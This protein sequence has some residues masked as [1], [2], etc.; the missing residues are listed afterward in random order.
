LRLAGVC[1]FAH[2][3]PAPADIPVAPV[4][5]FVANVHGALG[6]AASLAALI[7]R[8]RS[9][10]GQLVAVT[11]LEAAALM[12]ASI[13]VRPL[14]AP[15][16]YSTPRSGPGAPFFRL[17]RAGDGEWFF[18][19]ALVPTIFLQA[20]DALDLVEVMVL[21]GVDGEFL[22]LLSAD[23]SIRAGAVLEERF[24]TRPRQHWLDL[25]AAAA[26][27]AAPVQSRDV[28]AASETL[29]A[30]GGR[31][32]LE[33]PTLGRVAVPASPISLSAMGSRPADP[34]TWPAPVPAASVWPGPAPADDP[35]PDPSTRRG[36]PLAGVRVLDLSQFVAGP[37][38]P[39]LLAQWGADVIKVETPTGDPYRLY[40]VPF[41]AVNQG[42]RSVVLDLGT[43]A[44]A[45]TLAGL[46][47]GADVLVD[48]LRPSLRRRL[49]LETARL[50]AINPRLVHTTL[51]AFGDHGPLAE[52]P[53]FDPLLQALSGL[54][55]ACGPPGEPYS[56]T[57]PVHDVAGGALGALGTLAAL[58][59]RDGRGGGQRVSYSLA[60]ATLLVQVEE[61]TEYVGRPP[62]PRRGPDPLGAEPTRRCYR[63]ADGW[64]AV[65]AASSRDP[66]AVW[67]GGDGAADDAALT[68]LVAAAAATRT[69]EHVVAELTA[70]GIAAAP[71]LAEAD[72]AADAHLEGHG[73]YHV[74]HG[75]DIGRCLVVAPI[76]TW[77]R[78]TPA[79]AT[80]TPALGADTPTWRPSPTAARNASNDERN[81]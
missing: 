45:A 70:L 30:V 28:W 7:E 72:L 29:A 17:Y 78:S 43:E 68:D 60:S 1:G 38:G 75:P 33:H 9:G 39:T 79:A 37:L 48:N 80:H 31:T 67:A 42:K 55:D 10:L 76:G 18:L 44:G 53:G 25:F 71:V 13:L 50:H 14:D 15:M 56:T 69:T 3:Q 47:A 11:G 19:G 8:R 73:V 21:P 74:V 4:G 26:V 52:A 27:P 23:V 58:V 35:L 40:N 46:V 24:A 20:L 54:M 51:T 5:P 2:S 12:T 22:N 6:A 65:S 64:V 81:E 59:A 77:S 57:T 62:S 41:T 36:A 32:T 49:Q 61:L 16:A 34:A 63:T 66:L